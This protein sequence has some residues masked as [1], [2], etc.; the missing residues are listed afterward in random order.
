MKKFLIALK[1]FPIYLVAILPGCA[2][3]GLSTTAWAWLIWDAG[4]TAILL[5]M[6]LG[7]A[8]GWVLGV[9]CYYPVL[10]DYWGMPSWSTP[11]RTPQWSDTLDDDHFA[12]MGASA[13]GAPGL[14]DLGFPICNTDGTPMI[15]AIDAKGH[16]YG[17]TDSDDL[18][19]SDTSASDY[20]PIQVGVDMSGSFGSFDGGGSGVGSDFG[21]P[22]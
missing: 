18:F 22:H 7:T 16:I 2:L 17:Q 12:R 14:P 19:G 15:G 11:G 10:R 4:T 8:V 5:T 20:A 13:I 9:I 1:A 3:F 21:S 6:G